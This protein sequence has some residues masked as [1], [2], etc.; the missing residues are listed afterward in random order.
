MTLGDELRRFAIRLRLL[1]TTATQHDGHACPH[2]D[3][4]ECWPTDVANELRAGAARLESLATK[5]R[6]LEQIAQDYAPDYLLDP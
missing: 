2:D 3:C 1:G 6:Q 4:L 5:I